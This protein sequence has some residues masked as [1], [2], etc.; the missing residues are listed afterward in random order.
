MSG[1]E[2]TLSP[3]E[4]TT[5]SVDARSVRGLKFQEL[6]DEDHVTFDLDNVELSPGPS[7]VAESYPPVWYWRFTRWS[8][9]VEVPIHVP[10][11]S[12][13]GEY[14]YAVSVTP[15]GRISSDTTTEEFSIQIDG[16]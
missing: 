16:N 6:P 5:L 9:T 12:P 2:P 4:E 11:D 14:Q 10:S 3:G 8:V 15:S 13:P 1:D 7:S